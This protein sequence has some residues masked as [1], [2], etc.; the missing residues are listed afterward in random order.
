M[1]IVYQADSQSTCNTVDGP[2]TGGT[3]VF[4]F[5]HNGIT[6]YGCI[7]EFEGEKW[8]RNWCPTA[9]ANGG[10]YDKSFYGKRPQTWG[11]CGNCG[12]GKCWKL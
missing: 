7:N 12:G 4:P 11:Y 1:I 6:H 8:N 2:V 5:Q 3:C 9:T 10:K